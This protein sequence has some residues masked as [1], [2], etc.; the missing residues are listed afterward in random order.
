[1]YILYANW[2]VSLLIPYSSLRKNYFDNKI[3]LELK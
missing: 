1:M 2:I 3:F